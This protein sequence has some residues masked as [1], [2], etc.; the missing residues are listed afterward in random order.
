[1]KIFL[2]LLS[3]GL[4][5]S[6]TSSFSPPFDRLL[7]LLLDVVFILT[8]DGSGP[9]VFDLGDESCLF[10]LHQGVVDQQLEKTVALVVAHFDIGGL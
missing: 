5:L 3:V 10:D 9:L 2:R 8:L 1:M 7:L 4:P 6:V